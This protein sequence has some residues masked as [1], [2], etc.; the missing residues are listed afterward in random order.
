VAVHVLAQIVIHRINFNVPTWLY[1]GVSA[2]EGKWI[3]KNWMKISLANRILKEDIP[4][5]SEMSVGLKQFGENDGYL[6][7][8][9]LADFL[10]SDYGYQKLNEFIR[11][12]FE[13]QIFG[14]SE[15]DLWRQWM[16]FL[17]KNYR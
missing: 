4:T 5:F 13:Y 16:H 6:L 17:N 8:Y 10:I 12:P 7:S 2:Y 9:T 14:V 11:N 15:S 1:Q 3:D